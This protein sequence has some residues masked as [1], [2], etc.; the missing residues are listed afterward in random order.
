MGE[1]TRLNN[2]RLQTK[3]KR[4]EMAIKEKE[5]L[6]DGLHLI[7][8]EQLK[9]ENQTLGEKTEERNGELFKLNN[10]IHTTVHIYAHVQEKLSDLEQIIGD[11]RDELTKLKKKRDGLR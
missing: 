10:K 11:K 8:F 6:G 2:I 4:L 1:R 3:L 7:D 9:I 5:K